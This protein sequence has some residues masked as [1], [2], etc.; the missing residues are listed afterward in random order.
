[1]TMLD[2]P[3]YRTVSQIALA[4][5]AFGAAYL[6]FAGRWLEAAAVTGVVALGAAFIAARDRLPTL[7]TCCSSLRP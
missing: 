7:F 6:A 1:M 3:A 5:S 2:R 4:I